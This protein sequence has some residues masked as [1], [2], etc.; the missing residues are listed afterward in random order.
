[1]HSTPPPPP[2]DDVSSMNPVL[3]HRST[4]TS[5]PM[6]CDYI[7]EHVR[8]LHKLPVLGLKHQQG[9]D[10]REVGKLLAAHILDQ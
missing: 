5:N 3:H 4:H 7:P 8:A 10:A 1:M 6:A 9:E 2:P